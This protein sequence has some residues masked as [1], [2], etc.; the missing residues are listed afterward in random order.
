MGFSSAR[1]EAAA[2]ATGNLKTGDALDWLLA[3][4]E[5]SQD[6]ENNSPASAATIS[7]EDI[8]RCTE[9]EQILR[10]M[11][12]RAIALQ[13]AAQDDSELSLEEARKLRR[14][15]SKLTVSKDPTVERLYSEQLKALEKGLRTEE[16]T[17]QCYSGGNHSASK[18]ATIEEQLREMVTK[19]NSDIA[20][21]KNAERLMGLEFVDNQNQAGDLSSI[22]LSNR[23][24][25]SF[26][27]Q[28]QR[29][30]VRSDRKNLG[31]RRTRASFT[32]AVSGDATAAIAERDHEAKKAGISNLG[33]G[34][35]CIARSSSDREWHSATVV[36]L[37]TTLP[38]RYKVRFTEGSEEFVLLSDIKE[39]EHCSATDARGVPEETDKDAE[40]SDQVGGVDDQHAGGEHT[41]CEHEDDGEENREE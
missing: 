32:K 13:L 15:F 7:E 25:N 21:A 27:R 31:A 10:E 19:H 37:A 23:T 29:L 28:I 4:P 2:L 35:A 16:R 41:A 30:K 11:Q 36:G 3:N 40:T 38:R 22:R 34:A 8:K 17:A 18:D 1:I 20:G 33:P 26:K 24:Y 5:V 14:P 9:N 39:Q 6:A 12:D